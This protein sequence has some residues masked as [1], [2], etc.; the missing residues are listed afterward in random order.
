M[1]NELINQLSMLTLQEKALKRNLNSNYYNFPVRKKIFEEL[2]TVK[3]EIERVKFKIRLE[4]EK[5]K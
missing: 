4:K 2:Q 1:N 3:M 5:E